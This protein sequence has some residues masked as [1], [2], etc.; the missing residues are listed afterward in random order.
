MGKQNITLTNLAEAQKFVK[1]LG[2]GSETHGPNCWRV[3]TPHEG[4]AKRV[5][6]TFKKAGVFIWPPRTDPPDNAKPDEGREEVKPAIEGY[7]I[8]KITRP[9]LAP[10]QPEAIIFTIDIGWQYDKVPGAPQSVPA[11]AR[12]EPKGAKLMK[13][14]GAE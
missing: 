7:P 8:G 11:L 6:D 2:C 1:E 5:A 9:P 10:G 14:E 12:E 13:M 3:T 4:V